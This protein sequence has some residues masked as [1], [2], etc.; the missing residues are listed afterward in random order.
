MS[1]RNQPRS[2]LSKSDQKKL[3]KAEEGRKAAKA[4]RKYA[5]TVKVPASGHP[6]YRKG[7]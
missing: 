3:D 1:L 6:M 7:R 2:Q 4:I 5:D